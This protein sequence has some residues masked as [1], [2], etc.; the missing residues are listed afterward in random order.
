MKKSEDDMV[1]T[2]GTDETRAQG[3]Y[4]YIV[5]CSDGSYYAGWTNDLEARIRH[6]NEGKQGAKYTRSRR[7]VTLV[8]YEEFATPQE[9]MSRE[10]HIKRLTRREKEELVKGFHP[11]A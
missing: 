11:N 5:E 10:W 7:P 6:H 8:Y 2:A 3:N 1:R 4:A 9:A